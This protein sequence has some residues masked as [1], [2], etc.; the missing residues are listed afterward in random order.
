MT[1][2]NSIFGNELSKAEQQEVLNGYIYRGTIENKARHPQ[3][4]AQAGGTLRL[5]TDAEWLRCTRFAV[6]KKGN[7]DRRSSHCLTSHPDFR[8]NKQ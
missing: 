5:L 6:T 2:E 3:Q 7:L 8:S 4:V 1:F